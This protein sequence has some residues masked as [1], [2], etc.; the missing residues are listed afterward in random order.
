MKERRENGATI[1]GYSAGVEIGKHPFAAVGLNVGR[2]RPAAAT[3][4]CLLVGKWGIAPAVVGACLRPGRAAVSV[5]SPCP[6][7]IRQTRRP[8]RRR[9]SSPTRR[10][11]SLLRLPVQSRTTR[12]KV[13]E[14]LPGVVCLRVQPL[15]D[16]TEVSVAQQSRSTC[17]SAAA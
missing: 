11:P 6:T 15:P 3:L 10:P 4:L 14:P 9:P 2:C 12:S 8:R 17:W 5:R 13:S 7:R 1:L 16:F